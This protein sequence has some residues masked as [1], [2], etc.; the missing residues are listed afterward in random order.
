[1]PKQARKA[2]VKKP[3]RDVN[4]SQTVHV[5]V[6]RRKQAPRNQNPFTGVRSGNPMHQYTT[7]PAY[8]NQFSSFTPRSGLPPYN[9]VQESPYSPLRASAVGVQAQ[10]TSRSVGVGPEP[11][12]GL[13]AEILYPKGSALESL[14]PRVGLI[15]LPDSVPRRADG[16]A[17][18]SRLVTTT[19]TSAAMAAP[20]PVLEVN[21]FYKQELANTG[22]ATAASTN[23]DNWLYGNYPGGHFQFDE[24][25]VDNPFRGPLLPSME[26]QMPQKVPLALEYNPEEKEE[27]E[28][29]A[30]APAPVR[31]PPPP[32]A[33]A[34]TTAPPSQDE[35]DR[36]WDYYNR[37][38]N[39]ETLKQ[40]MREMGLAPGKQDRS[41]ASFI[42]RL[43]NREFGRD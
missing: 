3:A 9:L 37:T 6:T 26:S 16:F 17:A 29:P 4:V 43:V 23:P 8:A 14:Y 38:F 7:P 2:K 1:M 15:D 25:R 13:R 40:R 27:E 32:P 36:R 20:A 5:H 34:A 42:T 24:F 18:S 21:P 39:M 12:A 41:K 19:S 30:P 11:V 31:T 35:Y 10:A 22:F 33:A 28:A